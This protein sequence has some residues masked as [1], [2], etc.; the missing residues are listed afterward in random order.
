MMSGLFSLTLDGLLEKIAQSAVEVL[1]AETCGVFLVCDDELSLEA[2]IGHREGGFEKG[3]RLKIRPWHGLT[4]HI[5]YKK[6]LFN[7]YG[8]DLKKH[9]AVAHELV[10]TYSGR[11]D[12][13]LALPLLR[14]N[15][16]SSKLVGLLRVD[17]KKGEDGN[18][19][20]ILHFDSEDEWILTLFGDAVLVAIEN[21]GLLAKLK[22]QQNFQRLLIDSSPNGIVAINRQGLV[23]TY[24]SRAEELLG[25]RREEVVDSPVQKLY[26]DSGEPHK[27]G[28]Q[29]KKD[30]GRLRDYETTARN[31]VNELIPVRLSA[32]WL[33]NAGD[34]PTGSAGY[35][36][37]LRPQRLLLEASNLL[38]T[39]DPLDEGLQKLAEMMVSQLRRSFCGVLLADENGESLI[40]RGVASLRSDWQPR[41]GERLRIADWPGLRELHER[42]K[43]S[44]RRSTDPQAAPILE[45][46]TDLLRCE[47]PIQSLLV[48]PLVR[49]GRI[50]G[51]LDL[52]ELEAD[53]AGPFTSQDLH[54]AEAIAAQISALVDRM[55]LQELNRRT[56]HQLAVLHQIGDYIQTTDEMDKILLTIL[57][58]VTAS[59]GLGFNRAVLLRPEDDHLIGQ[60]AIGEVDEE[61]AREA[62]RVDVRQLVD[63]FEHYLERLERGKVPVTTLAERVSG[64]RFSLGE[65][66]HFAKVIMSRKALPIDVEALDQLPTPFLEF[67]EP[68]TSVVLAPLVAKKRVLGVLAVD[69]KFTSTQIGSE[70]IDSLMTF[71]STA[72]IVLENKRL[73]RETLSGREKLLAYYQDSA[74]LIPQRNPDQILKDLVEQTYVASQAWGV[75]ILLLDAAGRIQNPIRFGMDGDSQPESVATVRPAGITI[76]VMTTGRAVCIEDVKKERSRVN[77]VLIERGIGAALCLPLSLPSKRIGV[78]WIHYRQS[79]RFPDFEIG[80]LQ[81]YVNRAATAFDAAR[82]IQRLEQMSEAVDTLA[83][84]DG[85]TDVLNRIAAATTRVLE[86]DGAVLWIY[87]QERDSFLPD[88]SVA[89]SV[90]PE[91]WESF[92]AK[93]PRKRGTAYNVLK[94]DRIEVE[95][96]H[97]IADG[98]LGKATRDFL[99]AGRYWSLLGVALKVGRESLGVLYALY[100][101]P[102]SFDVEAKETARTFANHAALALKKAKLLEQVQRARLSAEGITRLTSLGDKSSHS[103]TL[104]SVASATLRALECG[105]VVLFEYV[106]GK[107]IHPPALEGLQQPEKAKNLDEQNDYELVYK[108]LESPEPWIVDDVPGHDAFQKTRFSREEKIASC[109]ALPLEAPEGRVGVMF[110]NYRI[111]RTFTQDEIT[112]IQLFAAQAAV[113]I[114]NARLLEERTQLSDD[115]TR[116]WEQQ[117]KLAQLSEELLG[118]TDLKSTLDCAVAFAADALGTE[119]GNI[120]LPNAENRLIFSAAVGWPSDYVGTELESRGGSQT[121]YTIEVGRP[122]AVEDYATLTEFR[123]PDNV[124]K[125]GVISGLSAPMLRDHKTVGAILVHT[126]TRRAFNEEEKLL[127]S[128]IANQ[129]A[130]AVESAR[131]F[132]ELKDEKARVKARTAFGWVGMRAAHWSHQLKNNAKQI[133]DELHSLRHDLISGEES[134]EILHY[135]DRVEEL[136]AAYAKGPEFPRR[137][138]DDGVVFF[139]VN[140][141][142]AGRLEI[143]RRSEHYSALCDP[144]L[145]LDDTAMAQG[146]TEWLHR[147]LDILVD[148][149]IKFTRELPEPHI[150]IGTYLNG[151]EAVVFV[152]DNG[153]GIP[154]D[155]RASLFLEPIKSDTGLGIG[156]LTAHTIIDVY[157]GRLEFID[158]SPGTSMRVYLPLR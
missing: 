32:A 33:Y 106:N 53:P 81:L 124:F 83:S 64:L 144:E 29:L 152:D 125:H 50:V 56:F 120:V 104:Q 4:G 80:A 82:R 122:V 45:R 51:Q 74:E 153:L 123:V 118:T 17:N 126:R 109:V 96:V 111:R 72:A 60:A 67:F 19:S 25:Y 95:D 135:V 99:T 30:K 138:E 10:H 75:N 7:E 78:M 14:E 105:A 148:N 59:Y 35:F 107:L 100:H 117:K 88:R 11:C 26:A 112:G 140:A 58:G 141:W 8:D 38:A 49:D 71:A 158:L 145:M 113:A 13:L 137:I 130:I 94:R 68:S 108:V 146:N 79:R 65:E 28:Q 5:A 150:Q 73:L 46:L 91:V 151:S 149:A 136:V 57:T 77:R 131:R 114:S 154:N 1:V 47:R 39:A 76:Q 66:G 133:Y 22:E 134:A 27:I 98:E 143:L 44:I 155:I 61:K 110:V 128:L 93:G 129:T 15:D 12:S 31:N 63:D 92:R 40:L 89:D 147:A 121:G 97:Y 103:A 69:N 42:G 2:S 9:R 90:E 101:H 139:P 48:V 36:E 87:D 70:L 55:R 21:A 156:L 102:R 62:W 115:K 116:Q 52:G 20:P 24:N 43:P 3:K 16:G 86:A 37:D 119:F 54:L 23:T 157:G 18:P 127:L 84:G 132:S 34:E 41:Q 142:L 85:A 6:E